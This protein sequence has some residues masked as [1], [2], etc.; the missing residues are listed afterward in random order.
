[1]SGWK[2][3]ASAAAATGAGLN[4]EDVFSTYLYEG[5]GA[6][7]TITNGI[8]LSAEGGL[9]WTKARESASF[10]DHF[11]V[12]SERGG[13]KT[14][15]SN[16]TGA[17]VTQNYISSFNTDGFTYANN[18]RN[19][20]SGIDYASWTFREAPKFFD[21]V[22]YTG[23]STAGR[24]VS[25]NLGSVPA[26]IIIKRL[27]L[28]TNWA[29]YH[30]SMGDGVGGGA[31]ENYYMQLNNTNARNASSAWWNNTAPTSTEFT[32]GNGS[33]VNGVGSPFVAYLFAHN[34][35]DGEFG[36]TGDQ[37][38]IKCGSYTGNGSTT[39][40]DIDLGFEPQWLMIKKASGS[41]EDWFLQDVMRGMPV[42]PAGGSNLETRSVKPNASDA[43][44]DNG[45]DFHIKANGFQVTTSTSKVNGNGET[46]IYT[47]IR[48]GPMAVPES[49]TDV[50]AIDT[51]Y[52]ANDGRF[53]LHRSNKPVDFAFFR[54]VAGTANWATSSRLIEGTE[55][56]LDKTNAEAFAANYAFDYQDGW[57]KKASLS[58]SA[59]T[60]SWMWSRAPNYFD[61]VAFTA[62]TSA[63]R[64]LDHNLGV[65]PEMAWVRR[66]NGARNWYVYHEG[67][68]A[69]PRNYKMHVNL[70]NAKSQ[71]NDIWGTSDPTATDFGLNENDVIG[72]TA[73]S[74]AFLFATLDGISKVGTYTGTGSTQTINC[75][76]STSARFVLIKRA[77]STG[78][79]YV[80]DSERGITT[81]S[82]PY[83]TLDT[84][85]GGLTA[86]AIQ[87]HSSGFIVNSTSG[88]FNASGGT[89]LFYA[90]A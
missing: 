24:T 38:I 1:M 15:N 7:K 3:L 6:A 64:R 33:N 67:M 32:L 37:D 74:I 68:D 75:G 57:R 20:E 14:L 71:T 72:A 52:S 65:A 23:N 73:P 45:L 51:Q 22:T 59:D 10:L 76:F 28:A 5:T 30:R 85:A 81:G 69:S 27:D 40:P 11:L 36:P 18:T 88:S 55:L 84:T 19:G 13:N 29:V 25:H 50:F 4:V 86:S 89:Y 17:E 47:A 58:A 48:R 35:G 70:S 83:N 82:D 8:D 9:V 77:D 42:T 78:N 12:D 41:S 21:C 39:G 34:D 66:R 54:Y 62:G 16:T 61:V 56:F 53:P 63:N 26:M 79:W 43:E 90:I 2:K 60:Y 46:Y 44:A 87:P 80:F 31:D 49:A